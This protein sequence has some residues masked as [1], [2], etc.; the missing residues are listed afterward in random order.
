MKKL[1]RVFTGALAAA[2]CAAHG[3][4][5]PPVDLKAEREWFRQETL[6]LR[7]RFADDPEQY[8]E[9]RW[10]W[11]RENRERLL[12]YR[13]ALAEA[14]PLESAAA[15][16]ERP[17][18]SDDLPP[19]MRERREAAH[20]LRME[21]RAIHQLRA[22]DPEAAEVAMALWEE[23]VEAFR[24]AREPVQTVELAQDRELG[25]LFEGFA[26]ARREFQAT[27]ETLDDEEREAALAAWREQ[28]RDALRAFRQSQADPG[29]IEP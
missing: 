22:T 13:K 5:P 19:E 26:L 18:L 4:E 17:L 27:L 16:P 15:P 25:E 28:R 2:A 6:V 24:T 12:R 8:G 14:E 1:I 29:G 7:E 20:A 11:R 3:G 23:R 10:Q 21:R 9:A